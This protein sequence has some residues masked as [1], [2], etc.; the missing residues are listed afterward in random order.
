MWVGLCRLIKK[1]TFQQGGMKN[2]RNR[3]WRTRMYM[4]FDSQMRSW[5]GIFTA[6][7]YANTYKDKKLFFQI[8][9]CYTSKE[10]YFYH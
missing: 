4:L 7:F 6:K 10:A 2:R 5:L 9:R 3:P 8:Y 1:R